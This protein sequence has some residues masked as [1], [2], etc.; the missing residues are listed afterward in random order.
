MGVQEKNPTNNPMGFYSLTETEP[1]PKPKLN[2]LLPITCYLFFSP[3]SPSGL[4]KKNG[5]LSAAAVT[6]FIREGLEKM[7]YKFNEY[8][9]K[10]IAWLVI[11][12]RPDWTLV[13]T[14][15]V[16]EKAAMSGAS[17]GQVTAAADLATRNKEAKTPAA[18]LWDEYINASASK[19]SKVQGSR[20]CGECTHKKPLDEMS[21]DLYG[22]WVCNDCKEKS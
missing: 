16:L 4:L 20:V 13:G 22:V 12:R 5:L 18:I 17:L 10:C 14:I 3:S 11:K 15:R 19:Q 21:R 7:T 8:D 9:A 2:P 6:K 1:N